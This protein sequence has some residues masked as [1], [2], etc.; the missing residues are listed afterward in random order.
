MIVIFCRKND[1]ILVD[2]IKKT[3]YSKDEKVTIPLVNL[4]G[5]CKRM[6]SLITGLLV[7]LFEVIWLSSAKMI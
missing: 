1:K 7:F 3:I 5:G 2:K 6:C 4:L